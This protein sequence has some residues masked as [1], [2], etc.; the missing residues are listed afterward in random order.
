MSSF[1]E[2]VCA[3]DH[4]TVKPAVVKQIGLEIDWFSNL[5]GRSILT[6]HVVYES[7][8]NY[9]SKVMFNEFKIENKVS[10]PCTVILFEDDL[11]LELLCSTFG[12]FGNFFIGCEQEIIEKYSSYIMIGIL[13][14]PKKKRNG[15]EGRTYKVLRKKRFFIDVAKCII[16]EGDT[17]RFV[18]PVLI[19]CTFRDSMI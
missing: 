2:K 19:S 13:K 11:D 14:V 6:G 15:K 7:E 8:K 4:D 9:R 18:D 1:I 17:K 12:N 5:Y 3:I 16:V 10:K